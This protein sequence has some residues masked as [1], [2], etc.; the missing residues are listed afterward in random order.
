MFQESEV[1]SSYNCLPHQ[2]SR[3]LTKCYKV[4]TKRI[5]YFVILRIPLLCHIT[6]VFVSCTST[7]YLRANSYW[8]IHCLFVGAVCVV[9][10]RQFQST[11]QC[12]EL[13]SSL[14]HTMHT[15]TQK[16]FPTH[17]S[18]FVTKTIDI[19]KTLIL[20]CFS[21]ISSRTCYLTA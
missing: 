13:R 14:F 17:Q 1:Y 4:Y 12:S 11:I 8:Y 3:I 9:M 2:V 21:C 5:N 20:L 18:I 19:Q 6:T 10:Y 16:S 15:K 7:I